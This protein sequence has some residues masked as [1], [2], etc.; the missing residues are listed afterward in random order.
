ML[1]TFLL[2]LIIGLTGAL[3]PGPM[4]LAT[5]NSSA[6][7]GWSAGPRVCAGH[8]LVEA[9]IFFILI[10]GIGSVTSI[11]EYAPAIAAIGGIALVIFGLMTLRG[12]GGS[13][14]EGQAEPA[15]MTPCLAGAITSIS[16]PYFWMWWFTVGSALVLAAASQAFF[17]AIAFLLGHWSADFGWYTLVSASIHQGRRIFDERVYAWILRGCGLFLLIFGL[18]Y[19]ASALIWIPWG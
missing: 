13:I 9:A 1:Q 18:Y 12:A 5:I 14:P 4:L 11:Q 19:L 15:V 16:N 7:G 6:R 3:V 10:L 8:A 17:F 2:G